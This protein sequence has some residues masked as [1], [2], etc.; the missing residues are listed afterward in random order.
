[1]EMDNQLV[2]RRA[3]RV[4]YGDGKNWFAYGGRRG[5]AGSE[6]HPDCCSW[7]LLKFL[8]ANFPSKA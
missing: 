3:L 4:K 5:G 1:M 6:L 2:V 8:L 7:A